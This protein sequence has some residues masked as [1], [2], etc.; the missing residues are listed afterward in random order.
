MGFIRTMVLGQ[1]N[2]HFRSPARNG[3]NDKAPSNSLCALPHGLKTKVKPVPLH[4]LGSKALTIILNGHLGELSLALELNF[5]S[6]GPRVL[7][8]VGDGFMNYADELDLYLGPEPES[9][10]AVD[11]KIHRDLS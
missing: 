2:R 5:S 7:E 11:L 9:V 1:A 3:L 10:R 6:R 8:D 4:L